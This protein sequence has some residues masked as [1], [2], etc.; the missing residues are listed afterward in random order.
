MLSFE[1]IRTDTIY[2]LSMYDR[3]NESLNLVWSVLINHDRHD[4]YF[5]CIC[6]HSLYVPKQQI[7]NQFPLLI[8]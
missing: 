5:T 6:L 7:N 2:G 3:L 1:E 8:K 4:W